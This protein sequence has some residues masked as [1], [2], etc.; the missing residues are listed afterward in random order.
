MVPT[1]CCLRMRNYIWS[2]DQR[3]SAVA[4]G[5][6]RVLTSPWIA[7]RLKVIHED[8]TLEM[9]EIRDYLHK[10]TESMEEMCAINQI[11][12]LAS[13]KLLRWTRS[14]ASDGDLR[15]SNE[16]FRLALVDK[17]FPG[18]GLQDISCMVT[19]ECIRDMTLMPT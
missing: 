13:W 6:S 12:G 15:P 19:G 3:H 8:T 9:T 1:E 14:T 17:Y 7:G 18:K 11:S 2:V 16:A 10:I 5:T 4:P